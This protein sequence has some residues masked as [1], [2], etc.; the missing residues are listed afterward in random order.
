MDYTNLINKIKASGISSMDLM[1]HIHPLDDEQDAFF[2]R[3]L[4][5][6]ILSVATADPMVRRN[7]YYT[8]VDSN[9]ALT[10]AEVDNRM[11]EFDEASRE[12]QL[13]LIRDMID[14]YMSNINTLWTEVFD[15]N[16]MYYDVY[17]LILLSVLTPEQIYSL[18][19][20]FDSFSGA[21]SLPQVDT[22]SEYNI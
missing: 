15:P 10:Q 13:N 1:S 19:F 8:Y 16:D 5:E 14:E 12:G 17:I 7:I 4:A 22:E 6:F 21:L 20:S 11:E 18:E 2:D 3:R 9:D